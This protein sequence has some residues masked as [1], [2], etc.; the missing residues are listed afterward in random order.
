MDRHLG[1]RLDTRW[2]YALPGCC[3]KADKRCVAHQLF[4]SPSSRPYLTPSLSF[5]LSSLLLQLVFAAASELVNANRD[6]NWYQMLMWCLHFLFM[7]ASGLLAAP[8][9]EWWHDDQMKRYKYCYSASLI[10]LGCS[11]ACKTEEEEKRMN[12]NR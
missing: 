7:G 6:S 11:A 4:F 12:E 1:L 10:L 3:K 2:C 5:L 9:H 8:V